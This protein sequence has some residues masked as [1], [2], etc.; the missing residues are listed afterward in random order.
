M[1]HQNENQFTSTLRELYKKYRFIYKANPGN[2]G[3]GVIAA[4]T[5]DYLNANGFDY[6]PFSASEVYTPE[7]DVLLFG[8]GGNLIEGYYAEGRDFIKNN[9]EKF[10]KVIIFP[11]TVFGYTDFFKENIKHLFVCCREKTSYDH[12]LKLGYIPGES[13]ILTQDMA[14]YL[15][16]G[17]YIN[18]VRPTKSKAS[19]YRTDS[20]S[21]TKQQYENNHDIS[22]TWNGDY[23]DNV[24]LARNSTRSLISFLQEYRAVDTD[25]LHVAILGSLLGMEVNFYPNSYYKNESV[26]EHS[27]INYYPNT[28]FIK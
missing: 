15:D 25:R 20:E 12:L 18:N 14:F 2:A 13:V 16:K 1:P 8:G 21:L 19:C 10:A 6:S 23:W 7:R 11:S 28:Y 22:L 4:A 5:Y 3:D 17:K 9:L 26:Y 27:L 24:D